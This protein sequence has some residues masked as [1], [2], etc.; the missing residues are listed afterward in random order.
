MN[1]RIVFFLIGILLIVL[2]VAMAIPMAV[3]LAGANSDWRSFAAGLVVTIFVGGLMVMSCRTEATNLTLREAFL[4][5]ALIWLVLPFFGSL[6]LQFSELDLSFTD[7]YFESVSG[8]T[9]TGS[10]VITGLDRLPPGLLLWRAILQWLGGLGIIVLAISVLPM[11]RVGGMQIFKV[12]AFE[13]SGNMFSSAKRFSLAV[14][15]ILVSFTLL[16]ITALYVA[17]MN[18]LEAT[19]HALTT[20]A[21]GGYSTSDGSVGHFNDPVI[22]GI[23]T[24]GMIAGGIPFIGY[25]AVLQGNGRTLWRDEQVRMYLAVLAFVIAVVTAWLYSQGTHDAFNAFRYAAFNA[26]SLMTGT[27]YASTDYGS[28]GTFTSAIFFFLMFIGGCYGSTACGIKIFRFQI[29]FA[30]ASAHIKQLIH[31]HRVRTPKYQGEPLKPEIIDSVL[32]FFL[33]FW[34]TFAVITMGLTMTGLDLVTA[35][36]GAGTAL[37]NVGPGLGEIIGPAGTFTSLPDTAKWMLCIAMLIGRLE[38]FTFF[39]ILTPDFWRN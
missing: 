27:G 38:V 11:L 5:T 15:S 26:T 13:T 7:A 2:S 19:V 3:D 18:G 37:S 36:S 32:S 17:G 30:A 39:V 10:T 9:T 25:I 6:P 14:A 21:T 1:Y 35:L 16:L 31:P 4:L 24:L 29:L 22:E 34:A 8:I 23:I 33:I 28:W 20:I 12:E